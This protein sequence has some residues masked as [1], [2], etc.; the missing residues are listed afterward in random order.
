MNIIKIIQKYKILK[1]HNFKNVKN[2]K[3]QKFKK[4]LNNKSSVIP[5]HLYIMCVSFLYHAFGT[6]SRYYEVIQ[7]V[8][9]LIKNLSKLI[10]NMCHTCLKYN[11][12]SF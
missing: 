2:A 7:N 1:I 11:T 8:V 3:I 12:N 9:H 4:S 10:F 5:H 6:I